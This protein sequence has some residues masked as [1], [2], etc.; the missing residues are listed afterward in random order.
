VIVIDCS[1]AGRPV[2]GRHVHDAVG[3]DVEG[4]LDLG[5][6]TGGRGQVDELELA[7]GLVELG[8]LTLALQHVDLHRR[9]HV[10]GGG[11][12][13]GARVGMVVLRSMSLV[14]TP[15]LV[16][17]PS[18]SGVTSSRRMSL[19]SPL[20]TPAWTAAP[21]ATTS[22]GLTPLWGSLAGQ[23]NT[24]SAPRACGWSHRPGSR[25]RSGPW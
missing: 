11:E 23:D 13:L 18:D 10:V 22:S 14:I 7:E 6:A 1:L 8:H 9:L 12:H 20:S 15:P 21:M 4:D 16:S 25:G 24:R 17:M 2:L 19:T 5:H 3:V